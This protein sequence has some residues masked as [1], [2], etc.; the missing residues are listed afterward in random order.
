MR[1][2]SIT[3]VFVMF[4]YQNKLMVK[5]IYLFK[6]VENEKVNYKIMGY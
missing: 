5:L 3:I 1:L 6:I 2:R 4:L